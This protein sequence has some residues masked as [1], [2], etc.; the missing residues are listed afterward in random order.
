MILTTAFH[1]CRY[2]N[3][4]PMSQMGHKARWTCWSTVGACLDCP[5]SWP[6][7]WLKVLPYGVK[8]LT[9]FGKRTSAKASEIL[10]E[11]VRI[12]SLSLRQSVVRNFLRRDRV[13]TNWPI[14][15]GVRAQTSALPQCVRSGKLSLLPAI[16]PNLR[17]WPI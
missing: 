8:E 17:T 6:K 3:H 9:S 4:P 7:F 13:P 16:S 10:Q 2:R 1:N 11:N 14:F 15:A 12:Q 5:E